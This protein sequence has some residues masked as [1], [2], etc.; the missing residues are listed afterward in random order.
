MKIQKNTSKKALIIFVL[1][2]AVIATVA[3]ALWFFILKPNSD[4]QQ[5]EDETNT[6]QQQETETPN[7]T[8]PE[9]NT[10][11]TDSTDIPSG[12]TGFN[13]SPLENPPKN[14]D[15]YPIE[16]EHYRIEQNSEKKFTITLFPILN[17]GD[18]SNYNSQLRIFK[19]E[20]SKYL[21]DRYGNISSFEL[22]WNPSNAADI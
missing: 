18:I 1:T 21:S 4:S 15:P 3:L 17:N 5:K 19:N 11:N 6:S 9:Q 12:G 22:I 14:N 20:A 13:N 16:N 10:G 2:A 8:A 7:A